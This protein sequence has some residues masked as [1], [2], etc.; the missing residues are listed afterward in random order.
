MGASM[1]DLPGPY[2][3]HDRL[4]RDAQA[5]PELWRLILGVVLIAL[6]VSVLNIALFAVVAGLVSA[7]QSAV[8]LQGRSPVALLLLL[9]SFGFIT[10][11]V[12]LVAR[13]LQRRSL[14]SVIGPWALGLYQ[15]WR[16]FRALAILAVVMAVLPPYGV[17]PPL[18]PNLDLSVWIGLLPFSLL[19]VLIQTSAE[20]VLFRGYIQQSLA[21][22]FRS[23]L[24][25]MGVPSLL[26][27]LGH[28]SPGVAGNNALL[29]AVWSC[30]FG[31]LAS[32]LTARAGTLGPAIAVHFFN[33]VI[34]LLFMSLPDNL[35][36]L[37]LFL[38]PFDTADT[39]MLRPWLFVDFAVMIVCW[40]TAR[41]ALR[42]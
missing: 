31:L 26:F 2:A 5:R 14:A 12:A 13:Q 39:E 15:F 30:A 8:L 24:I 9:G 32:D 3:A 25:W 6:L 35:S 38:L 20:E 22:R 41:L 16:V 40:L 11:G 18:T 29:I 17:G 10:L 7:E 21:A 19:A 28:Y 4:V 1:S 34:A 42:R 36:G 23:P 33:N 37:A 27:A